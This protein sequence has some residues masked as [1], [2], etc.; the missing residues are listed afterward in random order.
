MTDLKGWLGEAGKHDR[1]ERMVEAK[2]EDMTCLKGWLGEAGK[3]DRF[4]MMVGGYKA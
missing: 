2:K 3:H 1:F 4:E